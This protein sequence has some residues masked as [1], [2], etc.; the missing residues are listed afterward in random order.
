MHLIASY[1]PTK[2]SAIKFFR[3]AIDMK[4]NKEIKP[5]D[6]NGFLAAQIKQQATAKDGNVLLLHLSN[7]SKK[8][9]IVLMSIDLDEPL[10]LTN[11]SYTPMSLRL[12]KGFS[13][14]PELRRY[15]IREYCLDASIAKEGTELDLLIYP[16]AESACPPRINYNPCTCAALIAGLPALPTPPAKKALALS[17]TAP[18]TPTDAPAAAAAVAHLVERPESKRS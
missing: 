11:P 13:Y 18:A 9:N 12:S 3:C 14:Q 1:L 10:R 2:P 17:A 8:N 5:G 6:I 7:S 16:A 4:F 15:S